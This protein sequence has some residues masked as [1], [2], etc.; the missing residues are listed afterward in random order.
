MEGGLSACPD[1]ITMIRGGVSPIDWELVRSLAHHTSLK[2][3]PELQKRADRADQLVLI[4]LAGANFWEKHAK[5][6]CY[7]VHGS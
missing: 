3:L 4:S 5:K 2:L 6:L 7:Y 1:E